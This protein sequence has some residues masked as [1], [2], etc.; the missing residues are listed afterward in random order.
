MTKA[1]ALT[2]DIR[3]SSLPW[4]LPGKQLSDAEWVELHVPRFAEVRPRLPCVCRISQGRAQPGGRQT[5]PLAII[6]TRAKS[7]PSFA[8]KILRK[9]TKWNLEARMSNNETS[10]LRPSSFDIRPFPQSAASFDPLLRMTDLCGGRVIGE[11]SDQVRAMCRFVEQAFDVD[12]SNSEDTSNRLRAT[13]FGYRSV[14][15]IV[16]VNPQKL[17]DEF[18]RSNVQWPSSSSFDIRPSSFSPVDVLGLTAEIQVRTLLE[19]A[20]AD[21][22]H[23]LTYKTELKVPDRIRRQFAALAA[24]LENTDG[25]FAAWSKGWKN[26]SRIS[27]PP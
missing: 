17:N 21:I 27:A 6:E 25:H 10:D 8:E 13:E 3:H 24:V 14:H 19:H 4:A 5:A 23:E 12:Q 15:Y 22:G 9:R 2:F 20:W 7:I 11:T 26:S 1:K 18:R 16:S